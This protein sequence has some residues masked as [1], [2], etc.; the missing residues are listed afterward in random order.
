M[1]DGQGEVARLRPSTQ[2]PNN[3]ETQQPAKRLRDRAETQFTAHRSQLKRAMTAVQDETLRPLAI[4]RR[5][6]AMP[7]SPIRKLAPLAKVRKVSKVYH[8][9]IGQPD[10]E[11]PA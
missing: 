11:T 7:A 6:Q 3:S 1:G 10:I 9:N 8:L 4:S 5:G 2:K